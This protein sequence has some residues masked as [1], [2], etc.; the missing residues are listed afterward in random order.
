MLMKQKMKALH[1][2]LIAMALSLRLRAI[3]WYPFSLQIFTVG[4]IAEEIEIK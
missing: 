4:Y 3:K 1:V 2:D